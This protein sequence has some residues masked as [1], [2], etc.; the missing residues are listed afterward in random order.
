MPDQTLMGLQTFVYQA[1][2]LGLLYYMEFQTAHPKQ[3]LIARMVFHVDQDNQHR[4]NQGL[5]DQAVF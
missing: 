1:G 4:P 3:S 2:N 5:A